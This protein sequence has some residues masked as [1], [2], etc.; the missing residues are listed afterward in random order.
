MFDVSHLILEN[1]YY[2]F[3]C[4]YF[5]SFRQA[6]ELFH[7]FY[8]Y[9][10]GFFQESLGTLMQSVAELEKGVTML[11]KHIE[12]DSPHFAKS[13]GVLVYM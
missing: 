7:V 3:H 13:M 11:S 6:N 4:R 2:T 10:Q 1:I 9:E 5:C 12:E 8:M